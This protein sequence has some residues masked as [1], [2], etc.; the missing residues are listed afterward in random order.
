ME[1]ENHGLTFNVPTITSTCTEDDLL[2]QQL[3][4]FCGSIGQ[5]F[6]NGTL[7]DSRCS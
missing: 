3:K 1:C 4:L 5:A 6:V 7:K 2:L